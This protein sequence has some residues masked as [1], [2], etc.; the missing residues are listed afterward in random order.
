VRVLIVD[1]HE[2][3]RK[4]LRRLLSSEGF[5]VCGD[6]P[7]GTSAI[8]ISRRVQPDVIMMD[9]QMPDMSG[10]K[11]AQQI[12]AESP[13]V[14]VLLM[15]APDPEIV[16]AARDAGIRGIVWKGSGNFVESVRQIL[17]DR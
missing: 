14:A 1:D 8:E 6:A 13:G 3:V 15:T 11:A 7:D 2:A 9:L 16:D 10:I 17:A 4:S 12:L 5:E